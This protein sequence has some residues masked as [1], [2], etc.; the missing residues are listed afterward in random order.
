MKHRILMVSCEGGV[1]MVLAEALAHQGW[2]PVMMG[3]ALSDHSERLS[4]LPH[5]G[6]DPH[7]VETVTEVL[8]QVKPTVVIHGG[9]LY[10]P[11]NGHDPACLV[12]HYEGAMAHLLHAMATAGCHR[13][14]WWGSAGVYAPSLT[15]VSE[16]D[17]V[18]PHDWVSS[19]W[20]RVEWLL[21]A[22][23]HARGLGYL[24]FRL[25]EVVGAGV[26]PPVLVPVYE[27]LTQGNPVSLP[28]LDTPEG[29]WVRD[30]IHIRDVV[31][32]TMAGV[33]YLQADNPSAVF[34]V[35]TGV[36]TSGQAWVD[37]IE[38]VLHRRIER[39]LQPAAFPWVPKQVLDTHLAR[40]LLQWTPLYGVDAMS[41]DLFGLV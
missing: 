21:N 5:I 34:N 25:G 40:H 39:V 12:S 41:R 35:G 31:A 2:A 22:T 29:T 3:S 15:P 36:G 23:H 33:S 14:I 16:T 9:V 11:Q 26:V 1:A 6:V 30:F 38:S 18:A 37:T 7:D 10:P 13:L 24:G 4:W 20:L 27:A 17:P 32:V 28:A 8:C 19:A